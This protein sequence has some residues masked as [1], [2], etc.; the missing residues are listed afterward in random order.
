MKGGERSVFPLIP[1]HFFLHGSF[2][3][4][5][6][7]NEL[8]PSALRPNMYRYVHLTWKEIL[9]PG[10]LPA[11]TWHRSAPQGSRGT[12][13]CPPSSERCFQE[14][15]SS[16]RGLLSIMTGCCPALCW[17]SG[18]AVLPFRQPGSRGDR[19]KGPGRGTREAERPGSP[20]H[21]RANVWRRS[22]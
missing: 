7:L 17:G 21:F 16:L 22:T 4:S 1:V 20:L 19:F 13:G 2:L 9:T 10:V 3:S 6:S 5:R 11:N 14:S 12:V 15:E 8:V 18:E